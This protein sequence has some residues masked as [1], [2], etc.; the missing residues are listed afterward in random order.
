ME[1]RLTGGCK[2]RGW[3]CTVQYVWGESAVIRS[4][5][6]FLWDFSKLSD[7]LMSLVTRVWKDG[8]W[9]F[10]DFLDGR[11]LP[12]EHFPA[13]FHMVPL[14]QQLVHRL[15]KYPQNSP[16]SVHPNE[17]YPLQAGKSLL[18]S[19]ILIGPLVYQG[20]S[21]TQMAHSAW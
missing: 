18:L 10:P 1:Q 9:R 3:D 14:S 8:T 16:I 13:V 5:A 20:P 12:A 6:G 15:P 21:R 4:Q 11:I 7:L 19:E 2:V 17:L